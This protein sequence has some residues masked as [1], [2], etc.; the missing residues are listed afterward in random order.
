MKFN[1]IKH[2]LIALCFISLLVSCEYDYIEIATPPPPPPP[3]TNDTTPV[4]KISYALRIEPIFGLA[5][6]TNCHSG[7][8]ALNLTT[9][10][11]YNSIMNLGMATPGDP[12]NSKIYTYP[13]PVTGSHGTKYQNTAQADSI[14]LWI[15]Q[16]ALNN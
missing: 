11:S 4:H 3:D 13:H 10:N 2:A 12:L 14:Y 5:T 8:L 7:G 15:Y 9:G 16:G 6:C 1:P